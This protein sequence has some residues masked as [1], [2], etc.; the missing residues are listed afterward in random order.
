MAQFDWHPEPVAFCDVKD[1]GERR[2]RCDAVV[3]R[4]A[5]VLAQT[6]LLPNLTGNKKTRSLSGEHLSYGPSR[7]GRF[8]LESKEEE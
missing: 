4:P 3:V 2:G 1:L 5:R 8:T 7:L 6:A